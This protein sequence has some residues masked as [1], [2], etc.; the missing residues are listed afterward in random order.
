MVPF[1]V[2]PFLQEAGSCLSYSFISAL[3]CKWIQL[4]EAVQD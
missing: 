4:M 1:G 3:L 2:Q